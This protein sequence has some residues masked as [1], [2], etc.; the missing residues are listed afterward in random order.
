MV[1]F[2]PDVPVAPVRCRTPSQLGLDRPGV[3]GVA[4]GRDPVGGTPV[5]A[6]AERKKARAAS[7]SRLSLN[8]TSTSAPEP[9]MARYT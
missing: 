2:Q 4:V 8:M 6:L 5:A 1:F 3:A 9:S 7:M